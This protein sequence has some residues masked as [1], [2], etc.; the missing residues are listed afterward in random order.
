MACNKQKKFHKTYLQVHNYQSWTM[1]LKVDVFNRLVFIFIFY[2]ENKKKQGRDFAKIKVHS[3]KV[4][5]E[6]K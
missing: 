2:E 5:S 4:L 1:L 6:G 3:W